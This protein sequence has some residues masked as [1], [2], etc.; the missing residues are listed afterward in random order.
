MNNTE[1][2]E[3]RLK[4][5]KKD[6]NRTANYTNVWLRYWCSMQCCINVL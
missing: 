1:V 2:T 6:V 5:R 4:P 3:L